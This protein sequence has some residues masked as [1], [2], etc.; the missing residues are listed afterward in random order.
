MREGTWEATDCDL[1]SATEGGEGERAVT[2]R[3]LGQPPGLRAGCKTYR[4][5]DLGQFAAPPRWRQVEARGRD[6]H[7]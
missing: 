7:G 4:R 5:A 6:V 1:K 2:V 3:S